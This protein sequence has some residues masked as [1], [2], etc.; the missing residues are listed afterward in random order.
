MVSP[1]LQRFKD[2]AATLPEGKNTSYWV[3]SENSDE[4]RRQW[5]QD[6]KVTINAAARETGLP[7]DLIAGI[8]WQ[9]V[10]GK[11]RGFDDLAQI[12]RDVADSDWSPI[13]PENLP[14]RLGGSPDEVSYGALSIQT[15][16]AAGVLG[17]DPE[18]LTD[19]QRDEIIA[20]TKEPRMNILISAKHLADLKAQSEFADVPPDQMTPEQYAEIG[21]RYNGGPN[22]NTNPDAKAYGRTLVEHLPEARKAMQ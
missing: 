15:R 1:T 8:A 16:R 2:L 11:G 13:T 3:L 4:L 17:Y 21:A 19:E 9:E 14:D 5:I 20:A 12:V 10:G 18:N 6:N 7:P 22:W